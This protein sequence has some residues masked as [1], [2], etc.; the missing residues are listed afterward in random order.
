MFLKPNEKFELALYNYLR[1][2][3]VLADTY[4]VFCFQ[5]ISRLEDQLDNLNNRCV[6][7]RQLNVVPDTRVVQY[8]ATASEM[9]YYF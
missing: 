3:A 9:V 8:P 4:F 6:Y 7:V 2:Q 1:L 5:G